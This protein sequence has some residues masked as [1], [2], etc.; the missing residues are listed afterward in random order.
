MQKNILFVQLAI[1]IIVL[2]NVSCGGT[3]IASDDGLK[4]SAAAASAP[5]SEPAAAPAQPAASETPAAPSPAAPAAAIDPAARTRADEAKKR[6]EDFGLPGYSQSEWD[7]IVAQQNRAGSTA[8]FN[9]AAAKYDEFFEKYIWMYAMEKENEITEKWQQLKDTG[10]TPYAPEYLHDAEGTALAALDQYEAGDYYKAD[11]TAGIASKKFDSLLYAIEVVDVRLELE[12]TIAAG[13]SYNL[14]SLAPSF[15]NRADNIAWSAV[16]EYDAEKYD[17]AWATATKAKDEYETLKTGAEVYLIRENLENTGLTH[18][19]GNYISDADKK[20]LSALE[21][22]RAG[23]Y[24]EAQY[25]AGAAMEDYDDLLNAADI[26]MTWQDM[27]FLGLDR[28]DSENFLRAEQAGFNAVVEYEK[29]NK[30]TA[31]S[32]AENARLRFNSVLDN[33]WPLY[34]SD[35]KYEAER[36]KELAVDERANIA[37][38][39]IFHTGDEVFAEAERLYA[40]GNFKS[41]SN[42]FLT[43]E[44]LYNI[45][46]QQTAERRR[47]AEETIRM[48][49]Q[50]IDESVG[51]AMEAE[52]IIEGGS[53]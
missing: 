11:E 45:S 46:R 12:E 1:L 34:A 49:N 30:D 29:G 40:S 33:A 5:S 26:Y 43:A 9:D 21:Q 3:P 44:G 50:R 2:I 22:Y 14:D 20:A 51:A 28:Y 18:L 4:S 17:Q 35:K 47:V 32:M 37:A 53:R 24:A 13:G 19:A 25:N 42:T 6:A 27:I 48:A 36:E 23:N 38:R 7:S 15:I 10:L 52:R 41:A 39:T 31:R 16:D 8:A